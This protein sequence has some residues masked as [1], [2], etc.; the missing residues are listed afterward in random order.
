LDVFFPSSPLPL[1]FHPVNQS[2]EDFSQTPPPPLLRSGGPERGKFF[3]VHSPSSQRALNC[4]VL[5]TLLVPLSFMGSLDRRYWHLFFPLVSRAL[6]FMFLLSLQVF[7]PPSPAQV[8]LPLKKRLCGKPPTFFLSF[9][10]TARVF[11]FF[12]LRQA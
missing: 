2:P 11:C 12:L 4:S 3:A 1:W 8:H 6:S 7:L 9:T 5:T 10:K